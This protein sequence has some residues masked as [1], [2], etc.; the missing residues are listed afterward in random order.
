ME[1]QIRL[2]VDE[3]DVDSWVSLSP[4]IYYKDSKPYGLIGCRCIDGVVYIASTVVS[5]DKPFTK[6]MIKEIIRLYNNYKI[7][8]I[9]DDKDY[10]EHMIKSLSRYEFRYEVVDGVLYSYN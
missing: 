3:C 6:S 8:L 7:C 10:H 2:I 5:P 1:E 4:K 9:T